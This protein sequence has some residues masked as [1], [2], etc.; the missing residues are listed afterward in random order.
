MLEIGFSV[1]VQNRILEIAIAYHLLVYEHFFEVIFL[2]R[3]TQ[4]FWFSLSR[5]HSEDK[6]SIAMQNMFLKSISNGWN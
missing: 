4:S 5:N 6:N 2:W 1:L 3:M